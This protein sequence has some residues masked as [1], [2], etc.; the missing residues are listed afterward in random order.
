MCLVGVF[1]GLFFICS[2]DVLV[3]FWF[4]GFD[5]ICWILEGIFSFGRKI[6]F[7]FKFLLV[8]YEVLMV[9]FI[10]FGDRFG[11]I[12]VIIS[13]RFVIDGVVN[14]FVVLDIVLFRKCFLCFFLNF[15]YL[16]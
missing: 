16:V 3:D 2:V 15:K 1:F 11:G 9:C 6:L 13:M 7:F 8:L 10:V 12:F 14:S 5:G 4:D